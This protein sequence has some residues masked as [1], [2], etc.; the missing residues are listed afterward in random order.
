M[1]GETD[2]SP[3]SGD[4]VFM[5]STWITDLVSTGREWGSG[6]KS[7]GGGL[8]AGERD[9]KIENVQPK[10][11]ANET[12]DSPPCDTPDNKYWEANVN[13]WIIDPL[14]TG[15]S[16]GASLL[17][18]NG[19]TGS[20]DQSEQ[21]ASSC[22]TSPQS[23]GPPVVVPDVSPDNE[24]PQ[25]EDNGTDTVSW[26]SSLLSNRE[27]TGAALLGSAAG[28]EVGS[29]DEWQSKHEG[30]P[31]HSNFPSPE[32]VPLDV[33]TPRT[34]E[35]GKLQITHAWFSHSDGTFV[36]NKL[37]PQLQRGNC[38]QSQPAIDQVETD[39]DA[40]AVRDARDDDPQAGGVDKIAQAEE[41]E[42]LNQV[43]KLVEVAK[44]RDRI[45]ASQI[46]KQGMD[47]LSSVY[48]G[49]VDLIFQYLGQ[50]SA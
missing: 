37:E 34:A 2:A 27:R 6:L 43:R 18:G 30:T 35:E 29:I 8:A 13:S 11:S 5:L 22:T 12:E 32:P 47:T 33:V 31:L 46:V 48:T 45:L 49:G 4:N 23:P 21:K 1:G 24:A 16:W 17:N 42:K 36:R 40:R 20:L 26:M 28:Y 14:S 3:P 9:E 15:R 25:T 41:W 38:P 50:V 44:P 7:D 10:L 39:E 19:D